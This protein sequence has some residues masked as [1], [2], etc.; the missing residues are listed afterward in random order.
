MKNAVG[1]V[2]RRANNCR[3]QQFRIHQYD[4]GNKQSDDRSGDHVAHQNP[5][6]NPTHAEYAGRE[7][8]G[9]KHNR[10]VREESDVVGAA[11]LKSLRVS[12]KVRVNEAL[13]D[14]MLA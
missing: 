12:S 10:H 6:G 9:K 4:P 3:G 7:A 2:Y 1:D 13:K 5:T 14:V 8:D 11:Q